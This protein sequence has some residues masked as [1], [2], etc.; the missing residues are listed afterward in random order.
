MI[1]SNETIFHQQFMEVFMDKQKFSKLQAAVPGL[2][3]FVLLLPF[4]YTQKMPI[5]LRFRD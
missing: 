3:A 1:P 4:Y 5:R 2:A